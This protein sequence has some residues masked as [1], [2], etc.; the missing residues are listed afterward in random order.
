M[1]EMSL[2][3]G[4]MNKIYETA[5]NEQACRV[6]KVS[7]WLGALSHMSADHFRE[8]FE[9]SSKGGIAEHAELDIE[10]SDDEFHPQAQDIL[11]LS[12]DV[13]TDK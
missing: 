1:H 12:I 13:S 5:Q 9:V 11:L 8:H 3:N 4:L 6:S 7:V 10:V 2:M